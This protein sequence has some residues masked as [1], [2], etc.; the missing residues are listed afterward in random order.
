[1]TDLLQPSDANK[2]DQDIF[3]SGSRRRSLQ[4]YKKNYV[5]EAREEVFTFKEIGAYIKISYAA[6]N[7]LIS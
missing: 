4:D 5:R 7:K 3:L 1:M 2:T 6:V